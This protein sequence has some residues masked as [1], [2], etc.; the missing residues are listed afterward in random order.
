MSYP[1][2][3]TTLL[4]TGGLVA[5]AQ[6]EPLD[7]ELPRPMFVG[8]PSNFDVERLE[9]PHEAGRPP[10]L[11]PAGITNVALDKPVYSSGEPR[12]GE[13][14][15]VTD[16]DKEATS[17]SVVELDAGHQH[18][19]IDLEDVFNIYAIIIWHYHMSARVY[20]SVVVQVS[21]DPDFIFDVHTLFNNDINNRLGLGVGEDYHYVE[22]NEGKLI[23]AMGVEGR[24]VRLHSMG[25]T[26]N[27]FNHYIE[28]EV[29][30][31]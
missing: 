22:T 21:D 25:N 8:T 18:V 9:E 29:Y 19:T 4:L 13:L 27:D 30:G 31:N 12:T 6:M 3:F 14:W 24:Y 28:V 5:E 15:R 7:I 11:A 26:D 16:G 10:F 2:V 1:I 17:Y 20:H 23:D